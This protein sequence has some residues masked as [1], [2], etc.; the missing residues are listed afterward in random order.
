MHAS[1]HSHGVRTA[2][3]TAGFRPFYLG[4]A[5][6]AAL[7]VP[8][9]L[10]AYA[11]G[12]ILPSG[13]LPLVWHAHEMIYGYG[14]AV[15]AAVLLLSLQGR[16]LAA[17]IALWLAGRIAM[18]FS[19]VIG[20]RFAAV[21]ELTFPA[22]FLVVMAQEVSA[23]RNWRNLPVLGALLALLCGDALVQ[24]GITGFADT[25]LLGNRIGVATL[26]FM[27]AFV[28]GRIVPDFTRQW[29]AKHRATI[30]RPNPPDALD[31]GAL[32][33][34]LAALVSWAAAPDKATTSWML[35]SGGTA[36]LLRLV[37]WRGW[38]TL[39]EPLVTILHV[40]YGWL[41]V[42]MLLVGANGV[43]AFMPPPDALH[44][45]TIGAIGTMTLAVMTRATLEHTGAR[46]SVGPAA[47]TIYGCITAA[48]ILRLVAPFAGNDAILI[49]WL[50]GGFWEAAF[51]LFLAF[52]GGML[53]RPRTLPFA[54]IGRRA[55]RPSA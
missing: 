51:V 15:L 16:L 23:T 44:A 8:L 19:A 2:L 26:L 28:G 17:M 11:G 48:A 36:V 14:A 47:M 55:S 39:R 32:V 18:L 10:A 46:L 42:G 38:A 3:F 22:V 1:G 4:A 31:Q 53:I 9:W 49:L 41:G 25:A 27:I 5:A 30:R 7:A 40:G 43:F 35:L 20:L 52:Y 6:W 33:L 13:S 45:F 54:A 37:R 12:L 29:L 50:A 34:T 24:L 21:A